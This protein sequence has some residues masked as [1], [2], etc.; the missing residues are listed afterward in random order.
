MNSNCKTANLKL[1]SAWDDSM[2]VRA[3]LNQAYERKKAAAAAETEPEH[4][5]AARNSLAEFIQQGWHVLE[6]TVPLSWNWHIDAVADHIQAV[7]EDWHDM[8]MW[9]L[10]A[11][12]HQMNPLLV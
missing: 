2:R 11:H 10:Q 1:T 9:M 12:R 4:V 8:Q 7:L 3:A 5:I 6:P